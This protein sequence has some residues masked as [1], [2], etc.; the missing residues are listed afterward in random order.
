ML[1]E[2]SSYYLES[3]QRRVPWL[4]LTSLQTLT[5]P[6]HTLPVAGHYGVLANFMGEAA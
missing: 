5:P 1:Q 6:L 4:F 3:P 2:P